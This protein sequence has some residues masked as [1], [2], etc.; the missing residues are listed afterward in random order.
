MVVA[1]CGPA[2]SPSDGT[3]PEP[4]TVPVESAADQGTISEQGEDV[5][6]QRSI[7]EESGVTKLPERFDDP[8]RSGVV[9][10]VPTDYLD[11]VLVDAVDRS[12]A[13]ESALEVVRA[14]AWTWSD[15][16]LGCPEPGTTYTDAPVAG[17]WVVIDTGS[18]Q[19]D[20]RLTAA[21]AFRVCAG[22]TTPRG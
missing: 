6:E 4:D 1:A 17:Y 5:G 13:D 14:E 20:Y 22:T 3:G 12:G 19:L 18:G 15:G 2:L 16:A 11:A 8:P 10:E 21:G 9:G 7:R